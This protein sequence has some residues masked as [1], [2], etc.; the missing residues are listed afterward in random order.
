MNTYNLCDEDL[1]YLNEMIDLYGE[2]ECCYLPSETCIS[3][4]NGELQII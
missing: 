4:I 2:L 1:K 3:Y